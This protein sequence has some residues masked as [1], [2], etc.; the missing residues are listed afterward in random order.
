MC[1]LRPFSGWSVD[2]CHFCHCQFYLKENS[3]RESLIQDITLGDLPCLMV[4]FLCP[5]FYVI[6]QILSYM[7]QHIR[8]GAN[9]K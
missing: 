7:N 9:F 1:V 4:Q 5:N 8:L 2:M 3:K 6:I